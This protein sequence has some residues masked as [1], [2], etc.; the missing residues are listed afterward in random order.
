MNVFSYAYRK[1][2]YLTHPWKF[3]SETMDNFCAAW[4][5]AKRGWAVRDCYELGPQLLQ[6]LPEMLRYLEKNHIGV[7]MDMTDEE[8][9]QWLHKMADDIEFLQEEKWETQNEYAEEFYRAS[10]ENRRTKRDELGSPTV[11]WSD[12]PDY[13]EISDKWMKRAEELNE[14]WYIRAEEVGKSF[15]NAIPKLWDQEEQ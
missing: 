15:F 8:W 11:T 5:R 7:P 10:E 2:Y 13:K 3:V 1:R 6:V 12:T 14:Q 9:T 4:Q